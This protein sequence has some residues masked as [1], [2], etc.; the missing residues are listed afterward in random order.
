MQQFGSTIL[1]FLYDGT[2]LTLSSSL[3][4]HRVTTD[5]G[6]GG[7]NRSALSG[8][9]LAVCGSYNTGITLFTLFLKKSRTRIIPGSGQIRSICTH[10]DGDICL[11]DT[12]NSKVCKYRVYE[13]KDPQLVWECNGVELGY[14]ICSDEQGLIYVFL[15]GKMLYVINSGESKCAISIPL[16]FLKQMPGL[17]KF[18]HFL[19]EYVTIHVLLGFRHIRA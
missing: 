18:V 15:A 9:I 4:Q 1:A 8:N 14:A 11:L 13:E 3:E 10:P 5:T 17:L 12:K 16:S 6:T 2:L 7:H 19:N